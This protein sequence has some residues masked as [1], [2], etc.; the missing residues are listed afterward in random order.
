MPKKEPLESRKFKEARRAREFIKFII[1]FWPI[2][3][4]KYIK[5]RVLGNVIEI[6]MDNAEEAI[7]AFTVLCVYSSGSSELTK[8]LPG[9]IKKN[10]LKKSKYYNINWTY[11]H[12][13]EPRHKFIRINKKMDLWLI[14]LG[15][16]NL[17]KN[18]VQNP[19]KLIYN[20]CFKSYLKI[21]EDRKTNNKSFFFEYNTNKF[22]PF[23]EI[24]SFMFLDE[25]EQ[26]KNAHKIV[27]DDNDR[28]SDIINSTDDDTLST[29]SSSCTDDEE[30]ICDLREENNNNN[31]DDRDVFANKK[32]I[33]DTGAKKKN[34]HLTRISTSLDKIEE[35]FLYSCVTRSW[36]GKLC[37]NC[38]NKSDKPENFHIKI[39]DIF[40]IECFYKKTATGD[41]KTSGFA[42]DVD[43]ERIKN[44]YGEVCYDCKDQFLRLCDFYSTRFGKYA[45]EL[46]KLRLNSIENK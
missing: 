44:I 38:K 39:K 16:K 9:D 3:K 17:K 7:L 2:D 28:G 36:A 37:S 23:N 18:L 45:R 46:K 11:N 27:D 6:Q 25:L 22:Y 41:Y 32:E 5:K 13:N 8:L 43:F 31:D 35:K 14:G 40:M 30:W 12:V 34:C 10:I 15:R 26:E 4:I 1:S 33:L 24:L 21:L 42:N 19:K 29:F 20:E